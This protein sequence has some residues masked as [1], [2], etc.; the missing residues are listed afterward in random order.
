M[1]SWSTLE[2]KKSCLC[3]WL[4]S[5]YFLTFLFLLVVQL[6]MPVK[7]ILAATVLSTAHGMEIYTKRIPNPDGIDG[8]N[9]LGH[10]A[11]G[12]GGPRN[13]FGADFAAAGRTWSKEL[14]Q[15]DSDKD[16]VSNGAELGDPCCTWSVGND[17]ILITEGLS[18][19]GDASSTTTS[20]D[21]TSAVCG[22]G[23]DTGDDKKDSGAALM[24]LS[25]AGVLVVAVTLL[26]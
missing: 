23:A 3:K 25:V 2:L 15:S 6:K 10:V 26:L 1:F 24:T 12:G 7:M 22:D 8:V 11:T 4:L 17:A 14:C 21:L 16:G 5:V 18:H 20:T 19:P 13:Q 9:A